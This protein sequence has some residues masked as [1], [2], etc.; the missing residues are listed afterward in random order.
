MHVE[1]TT[2]CTLACPGCPRTV[3]G[4]KLGHYPKI[5]LDLDKFLRFLDCSA[6][7]N[8]EKLFLEGNHG[9]PIYYPNLIEFIEVF[10]SKKF[11]IVTN[12]SYRDK[13]F[14]EALASLMTDKDWIIFSIDG[15]EHNNHLYRRNSDWTTT[16]MGLEIMSKSAA[17]VGWKTLIFNYNYHE[18]DKIKE[19]AESKGAKF[20]SQMTSRF[21]DESLRPPDEYV[22]GTREYSPDLKKTSNI[23]PQCVD[24]KKEY[25]S[26]DG[27]YWPCCWI[28]SAFTL[29]KS[30]IWKARSDWSIS[31][32]NLDQMRAHLDSWIPSINDDP[33]VVCRMMCRSENKKFPYNHGL[34]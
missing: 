2:R 13:V 6:G 1:L 5:D 23:S 34:T 31:T 30:K 25:V 7:R 4:E 10:R 8:M 9:D 19:F 12:G 21:G 24:H 29:P 15:L 33:D 20:V 17:N 27:F 11:T 3:I 18:I 14:W 26:A 28:S 16:M 32:H 22:D